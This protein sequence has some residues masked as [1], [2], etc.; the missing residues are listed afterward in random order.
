MIQAQENGK[1]LKEADLLK[2]SIRNLIGQL[3]SSDPNNKSVIKKVLSIS[4][5][6]RVADE[7]NDYSF[8]E[9]REALE[10]LMKLA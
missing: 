3:V 9:S 2:V 4:E 1:A 7:V 6:R 8:E 10:K 5:D